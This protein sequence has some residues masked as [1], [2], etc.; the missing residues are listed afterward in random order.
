[1]KNLLGILTP[2]LLYSDDELPIEICPL[3]QTSI[4]LVE[5][6]EDGTS[7]LLIK[8]GDNIRSGQKLSSAN[9]KAGIISSVTGEV[10]EIKELKWTEGKI[11]DS[12]SIATSA[13]DRWETTTGGNQDFLNLSKEELLKTLME[14]GF[15]FEVAGKIN[16]VIISALDSDLLIMANQQILRENND[17]IKDGIKLIKILTGTDKV[18]LAVPPK[19]TNTG[20]KVSE[21]NAKITTIDPVYPNGM[22]EILRNEVTKKEGDIGNTIIISAEYLNAMVESLRSGIPSVD[23]IITLI[24]KNQRA[25]KNLRVRIGTPV[26]EILD[27]NSIVLED[28]EKLI[29]GGQMQGKAAYSIDSPV[30]SDTCGVYV[31]NSKEVIEINNSACLNC[32]KCV[33]I[34][35]FNIQVNLLSRFAEFSFFEKCEELNIDSCNECG[36][37]SYICT[38][39]RPLVQLIQFAKSEIKELEKEESEQ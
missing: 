34:C 15:A 18:I 39:R 23:K 5:R 19:L 25:L 12:I 2:K 24:D 37:C 35:P 11:F 9:G 29:L 17:N 13:T 30:I 8:V 28:N 22:P 4:L 7:N 21:G 27:A 6:E 33:R 38:A 14:L 36:L 26:S 10:K 3:P 1:M 32:G 31:Q 20:E 16:T